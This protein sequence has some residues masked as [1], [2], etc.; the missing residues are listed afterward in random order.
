MPLPLEERDEILVCNDNRDLMI[1]LRGKIVANFPRIWIMIH[2][3]MGVNRWGIEVAD[4]WGQP[5]PKEKREKIKLLIEDFM[6]NYHSSQKE[7]DKP[8]ENA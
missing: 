1:E 4:N 7:L 5:L 6:I 2:H 3:D 8:T